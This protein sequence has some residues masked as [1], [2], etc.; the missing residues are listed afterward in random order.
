MHPLFRSTLNIAFPRTC[1]VC[2]SDLPDHLRNPLCP[3]CSSQIEFCPWQGLPKP[4]ALDDFHAALLFQGNARDLLHALKYNG[5][6]YLVP[7]LV[8]LWSRTCPPS[9][10]EVDAL[11]PVPMPIWREIRR[12]YNQAF[13]LAMELG[14]RLRK[15]IHNQ[16]LLR[17]GWFPSQT[18]LTKKHRFDNAL[19]SYQLRK[20]TVKTTPK[21][22]VLVDDIFTTG[23][24]MNACALL[25]KQM[26]VQKVYGT[27]LAREL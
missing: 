18:S 12:G 24:T 26:G 11:V 14:R 25:L 16:W 2:K 10:L 13:L 27:T 21:T 19:R 6:D 20:G 4:T 17:R 22:V 5:K 7:F 23:S 9:F 1:A 15:P 3:R 8:D